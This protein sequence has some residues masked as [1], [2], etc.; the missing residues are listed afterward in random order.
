MTVNERLFT[1]GLLADFDA[2][3]R[4]RDERAMLELLRRS[5][6]LR[7]TP[8]NA[9]R[10]SLPTPHSLA[11]NDNRLDSESWSKPVVRGLMFAPETRRSSSRDGQ[12]IL[13]LLG[14]SHEPYF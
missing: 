8:E 9:W 2:A 10:L 5:N 14:I 11:F 3:A 7:L 6:Y 1:L 4:R 13:H 12:G